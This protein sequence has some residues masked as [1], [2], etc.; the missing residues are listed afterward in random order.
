MD[1][2]GILAKSREDNV[3]ADERFRIMEWRAC[4][5]ALSVVMVLWAILFLWDFFHGLDTTGLMVIGL[6]VPATTC[7]VRYFQTRMRECIAY[8][9]VGGAGSIFFLVCHIV[10]T[11]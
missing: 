1:K 7:V 11:L 4:Y 3:S 9:L 5:I 10:E 2:E 8:A 6:S